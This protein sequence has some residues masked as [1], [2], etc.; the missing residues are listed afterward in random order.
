MRSIVKTLALCDKEVMRFIENLRTLVV[1]ETGIDKCGYVMNKEIKVL[2]DRSDSRMLGKDFCVCEYGDL[3]KLAVAYNS[4]L[5]KAP[6]GID[7]EKMSLWVLS[8]KPFC[9][10]TDDK[11]KA[12]KF[13][14]LK[15]SQSAF[16]QVYKRILVPNSKLGCDP[17]N[18][19]AKDWISKLGIS[20][21]IYY[22]EDSVGS[23]FLYDPA[24][25][26]TI[27]IKLNHTSI[28]YNIKMVNLSS[29]Y[30]LKDELELT[31]GE[32]DT[33]VIVVDIHE[34]RALL[35]LVYSGVIPAITDVANMPVSI[36][37]PYEP[38]L[39]NIGEV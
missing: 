17:Y 25:G 23:I 16:V 26:A 20:L 38:E 32:L 27:P 36:Q 6:D 22:L 30:K 31:L 3:H 7:P 19:P 28:H 24:K 10:K 15:L 35:P 34:I 12:A 39:N 8:E 5:F 9:D 13:P 37:V 1:E 18:K 2:K 21:L 14:S 33:L 4:G 11:D 29:L